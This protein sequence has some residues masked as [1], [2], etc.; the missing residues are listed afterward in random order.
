MGRGRDGK[1]IVS[2]WRREDGRDGEGGG[3]DEERGGRD[4]GVA[5]PYC[6]P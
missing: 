4:G 6:E 1:V 2:G 3:R 5:V